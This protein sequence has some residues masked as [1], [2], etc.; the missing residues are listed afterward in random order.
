MRTSSTSMPAM[1]KKLLLLTCPSVSSG[2]PMCKTSKP[3]E[4][5]VPR[6]SN[7][8]ATKRVACHLLIVSLHPHIIAS[9]K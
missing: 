5:H 1:L 8:A 2:P 9:G 4:V 7:H 6:L 3:L